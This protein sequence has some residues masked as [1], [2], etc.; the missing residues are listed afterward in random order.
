MTATDQFSLD[1]LTVFERH[2]A[3]VTTHGERNGCWVHLPNGWV[4]SIQWGGCMYGSNYDRRAGSDVPPAALAE[5][6]A[7]KKDSHGRR[8]E[9]VTWADGDTVQGYCSMPRVLHVLDLM[10]KDALLRKHETSEHR[11]IDG[12]QEATA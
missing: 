3:R 12:W 2:G 8:G 4:L 10:A 7:W 1:N 6:A 9:M 11:A 5:I